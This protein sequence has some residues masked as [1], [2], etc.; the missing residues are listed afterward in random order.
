MNPQK[1]FILHL[2]SVVMNKVITAWKA[3]NNLNELILL[4]LYLGLR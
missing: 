1:H 3:N 4:Q 2:Q